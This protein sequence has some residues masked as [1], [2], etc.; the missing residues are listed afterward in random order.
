MSNSAL[1]LDRYFFVKTL[2]EA[3]SKAD[4]KAINSIETSVELSKAE[5]KPRDYLISLTVRL[6]P[7]E[8]SQPCYLGEFVVMGFFKVHPDYPAEK[9]DK[10]V[11][12]N[13]ASI[14][15]G[16]VREMAANL[17]ARGP[18]PMLTLVAMNFSDVLG[19]MATAKEVSECQTPPEKPGA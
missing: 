13:G 19:D 16:V 8:E 14:L 7:H 9:C 18:W 6:L 1:L 17:T 5:G 4:L 11:S 2:L 3:Q 12:V 15:Y 10:L